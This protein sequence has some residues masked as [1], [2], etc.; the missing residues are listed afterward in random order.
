MPR[1][2]ARLTGVDLARCLALLG[3]V[4]VHVLPLTD[5]DGLPTLVERVAGGR[6]AALF[7]V[8]AGV[9]LAL[10]YGPRPS[11][12]RSGAALLVRAALV[13][14]V[15]LLLGSVDS[16]VAVI[17]AYY[18]LLF[19][20]VWPWLRAGPRVL[21]A[22]AAVVA[23]VLPVV[24]FLVRDDL[25]DRESASPDLA[26]LDDPLALLSELALTGYYPALPWTAYLLTGLAVG[27]LALASR[28]TAAELVGA[29]AL[30]A[31]AAAA[32]SAVLLGP[33]GGYDEIARAD[34]IP[35]EVVELEVEAS[36]F[37][38]VPTSTPWWLA[39][40]GAHT[41][42]PL[43]LAGTTGTAL[44]ALGVALL[45]APLAPRLLSPL[46]AAGSMPLTLYS[47]HV[48]LLGTTGD[49]GDPLRYYLLQ[50]VAGLGFA[51][52]WQRAVGRG[53]LEAV[54]AA[55]VRPLRGRT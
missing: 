5:E 53:P 41:T 55:A 17:L 49:G 26:R 30:L 33:L 10:A 32:V 40:D 12:W 27:R 51:W 36:R 34:D 52:L 31:V 46:T 42:T 50:V 14:L 4:A 8:L 45:V 20:L 29:G 2:S 6:S 13:G 23:A 43:D 24:S 28:R 38:N 37:G 54:V 44:V 15:G 19:V 25:P 18:G 35:A 9:S 21:T 3:M 22:S 7:A 11:P 39:S 47:A 48:L 16:G 1:P